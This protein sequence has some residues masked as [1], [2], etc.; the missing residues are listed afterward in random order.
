M[1]REYS[2]VISKYRCMFVDT[3]KEHVS[4]R[5]ESVRASSLPNIVAVWKLRKRYANSQWRSSWAEVLETILQLIAGLHFPR[6]TRNFQKNDPDP[7][8]SMAFT[9]LRRTEWRNV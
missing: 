2:D 7:G 9:P 1:Q 8:N 4:L 5:K 6:A 3:I